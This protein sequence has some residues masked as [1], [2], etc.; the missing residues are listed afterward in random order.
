[1]RNRNRGFVL[2]LSL[3]MLLTIGVLV[4]LLTEGAIQ[5]LRVSR[6][7]VAAA[8]A[9]AAAGTAL[10]S[11]LGAVPDSAMLA[12]PRGTRSTA[13][14]ISGGDTTQLTVQCL[15]AGLVRLTAG[16]RSWLAGMR[17]DAGVMAFAWIVA[18]PANPPAGLHF[19]R[20]PGWWWAELP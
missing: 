11:L 9:R 13:I 19:V 18:D 20:L 3:F 15:G 5:E 12:L 1:M 2:P 14:S 8:R 16:A 10:S 17:A 6:G 4:A 7:D